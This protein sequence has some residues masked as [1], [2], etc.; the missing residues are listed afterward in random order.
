MAPCAALLLSFLSPLLVGPAMANEDGIVGLSTVGCGDCHGE[1]ASE[2][3]S[4][5]FTLDGELLSGLTVEGGSTTSLGFRVA[6]PDAGH[7]AAGLNVAATD[8]SLSPEATLFWREYEVSHQYPH[9]MTDGA[10][11]FLVDWTAPAWA[12][13]VT[14]T[15]AGNAVNFDGAHTGDHWALASLE[16]TVV[17]DCSDADGDKVGDCE[18]DCDD[19]DPDVNPEAEETWYDGVDSDCDGA[20]DYDADGDG[21]PVDSDCDDADPERASDCDTGE[22]DSGGESGAGETGDSGDDGDAGEGSGS[23]GSTGGSGADDPE[24]K[25]GCGGRAALVL[26]PLALL[27]LSLRRRRRA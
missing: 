7:S 26:G 1:A 12:T 5:G 25:D 10:R 3:I 13:T 22:P 15:G 23:D 19:S 20:D 16:V 14:L 21:V 2:D 18:G 9:P 24:G 27:G 17:A 4:V 8:G 11:T 6:S